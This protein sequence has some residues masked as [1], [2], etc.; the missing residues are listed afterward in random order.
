MAW[1]E[2]HR[3]VDNGSQAMLVAAAIMANRQ[4]RNWSGYWQRAA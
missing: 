1:R 4:S 2:D 3:R